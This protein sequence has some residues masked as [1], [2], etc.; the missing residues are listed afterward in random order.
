MLRALKDLVPDLEKIVKLQY[1]FYFLHIYLSLMF[2]MPNML[3]VVFFFLFTLCSSEEAKATKKVH[4]DDYCHNLHAVS[5]M[6]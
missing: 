2:Y 6:M 3:S 4:Q 1:V 5:F